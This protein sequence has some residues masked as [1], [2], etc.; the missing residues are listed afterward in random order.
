MSLDTHICS[1]QTRF[2]HITISLTSRFFTLIGKLCEN[3]SPLLVI[4]FPVRYCL[5]LP[6][7]QPSPTSPWMARATYPSQQPQRSPDSA[8]ALSPGT[9][10]TPETPLPMLLLQGTM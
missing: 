6:L 7:H 5:Y 10:L 4:I 2:S 8:K 3:L 9:A 1:V